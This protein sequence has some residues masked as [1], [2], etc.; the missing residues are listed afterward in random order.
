MSGWDEDDIPDQRGRTAL[1]TGANSG[2]GFEAARMLADHGA[3]VLLGCRSQTRAA[4]ALDALHD[5]V[6]GADATVVPLDLAD[7]ASVRN[8]AA[9][10]R[11]EDRLDLLINNAGVMAPPRQETADGFELQFG[12]NH[13][14]HFALTGLLLDKLG[15][16]AGSRVV[17]VSSNAHKFGRIRFGD[18]QATRRYSRFGQYGMSKLA[19]ILFTHELQR[20]LEAAGSTTIAVA[21]H[22]GGSESNLGRDLPKVLR[23]LEPAMGWMV[24]SA[25]MGALPTLRAATDPQVYGAQYFGPDGMGEMAGHPVVVKPSK[26]SNDREIAAGLWQASIELTGVDPGI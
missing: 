17:T 13:L 3:R 16:Q 20:R 12:V 7:L 9:T 19:N 22:P 18:L 25:A 10:V 23:L 15:D 4:E 1:V 6:P 5:L 8:A 2:I 21:G 14:G 26:R 11:T 24:Q